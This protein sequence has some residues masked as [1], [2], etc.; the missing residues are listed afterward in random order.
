MTSSGPASGRSWR[1]TSPRRRASL[2][3]SRSRCAPSP[4]CSGAAGHRAEAFALLKQGLEVA[5]EHDLLEDASTCYFILSD[6]CFRL[7][8]YGEALRYL[9]ESLAL[10]GRMGSRPYELGVQAERTYALL[11]L[12]RWDEVLATADEFTEE[13]VHSGGVVLSVPPVRCRGPLP[14]W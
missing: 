4:P 13:H 8:R 2:A 7:D 5:L 9:D 11:M 6:R 1:W 3:H 12:G 10:A 14:P